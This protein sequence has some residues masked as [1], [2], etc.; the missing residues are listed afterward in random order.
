MGSILLLCVL[1]ISCSTTESFSEPGLQ[2]CSSC[3]LYFRE[4]LLNFANEMYRELEYYRAIT[5]YRRILTFFPNELDAIHF[6]YRIF[7]CY[8]LSQHYLEAL[9]WARRIEKTYSN[10]DEI[11]S[12]ANI[13]IGDSLRQLANLKGAIVSYSTAVELGGP[14]KKGR[15]LYGIGLARTAAEDWDSAT[16][17]FATIESDMPQYSRAQD[18]LV[19]IREAA[20][21]PRKSPH[22]ASALNLIP[23]VGYVYVGQPQTGIAAFVVDFLAGFATYSAFKGGQTGLGVGVGLLTVGWYTGGIYGGRVGAMKYNRRITKRLL[24]ELNRPQ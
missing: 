13:L 2:S 14:Q 24:N 3:Q 23:G 20:S 10:N 4:K 19:R 12:E 16:E 6:E 15:A 7:E 11:V 5:E 1:L 9:A 8:Y 21:L 17:A 22:L 18:A